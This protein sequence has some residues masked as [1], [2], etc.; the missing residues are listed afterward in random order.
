MATPG[1]FFSEDG[2][3]PVRTRPGFDGSAPC[4]L[5][6]K[7][8]Y[9]H[10]RIQVQVTANPVPQPARPRSP[11]AGFRHPVLRHLSCR[12]SAK[13]RKQL[14]ATCLDNKPVQF[15]GQ[16]D[17]E[18]IP[19]RGETNE[20]AGSIHGGRNKTIKDQPLGLTQAVTK[21][22]TANSKPLQARLLSFCS[23]RAIFPFE[24]HISCRESTGRHHQH[25]SG[26]ENSRGAACFRKKDQRHNPRISIKSN[27]SSCSAIV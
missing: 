26:K 16:D 14:P 17:N 11:A 4:P 25:I 9:Q 8:T 18:A 1:E 2:P 22:C 19:S 10:K 12:S 6:G 15:T 13:N 21:P 27:R 3:L 24:R 5:P 20:Q 7:R 23:A